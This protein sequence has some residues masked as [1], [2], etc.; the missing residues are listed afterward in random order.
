MEQYL[1]GDI[2]VDIDFSNKGWYV[3]Y[4]KPKVSLIFSLIGLILD[5]FTGE[6]I[7][8]EKPANHCK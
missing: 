4:G 7:T 6:R 5:G 2:L 3:L 1:I 8:H